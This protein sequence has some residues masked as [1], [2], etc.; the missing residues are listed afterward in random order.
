MYKSTGDK[1]GIPDGWVIYRL[2]DAV[3]SVFP[4]GRQVS[5]SPILSQRCIRTVTTDS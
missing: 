1:I 2:G 3:T 4:L 5:I